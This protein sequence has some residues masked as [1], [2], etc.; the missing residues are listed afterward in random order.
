MA[1][2]VRKTIQQKLILEAVRAL[3]NHPTMD[4][5]YE[6]VRSR[7]PEI[8][9]ATVYRNLSQLSEEGKIL[10]L[11]L[12]ASP[13]RY[14]D[15]VFPHHHFKC[16]QCGEILD[17]DLDLESTLDVKVRAPHGV[18]IEVSN[19]SFS[20]LCGKCNVLAEECQSQM[21]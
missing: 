4:Q 6:E 9:K 8:G 10:T 21:P 20:G 18:L 1:S 14:D 19:I 7:Y 3:H 5:V 16:R 12:P 13:M 2:R 15:S 11:T 17:V